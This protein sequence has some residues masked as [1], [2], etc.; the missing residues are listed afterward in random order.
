[1]RKIGISD[2]TLRKMI[3]EGKTPVSFN[4]KTEIVKSLDMLNVCVIET[5][6][7]IHGKKDVLFL[8]TVSML[9]KNSILACPVSLSEGSIVETY[10]AIKNAKKCRL[11]ISVPVSTVQMEYVCKM[12][13]ARV[14]ELITALTTKAC[15]LCSDVEVEFRDATR[16]ES[17]FLNNAIQAAVGAGA[18]NISVCDDAGDMFPSE[19]GDFI[20]GIKNSA[21]V[22]FASGKLN[23][24]AV[25]NNKLGMAL[26]CAASAL[27]AGADAIKTTVNGA[28][29]P[30]LKAL[31]A[32][33]RERGASLASEC[34]INVTKL[35][36]VIDKLHFLEDSKPDATVFDSGTGNEN[37]GDICFGADTTISDVAAALTR[38][39]YELSDDDVKNVYDELMK[40]SSKKEVGT[41]E[42]DTIIASVAM[43]VPPTFK[44]KSFVINSGD[45]ITPTANIELCKNG[46]VLRGFCIGNGPIDAAFL[47][48][49]KITGHHYELDDFQIKAVTEGFEAMGSAVVKLRHNGK[50]FSGSGTSTDI[51]GASI[52][53]YISALNKITYEEGIS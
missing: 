45:L 34:D 7:I 15:S 47:A 30:S 10:D 36:H 3:E 4:E 44:V 40:T 11:I 29:V 23:L 24:I 17:E 19:Y 9:V 26:A 16:A 43:Q 21:G 39:G 1:M 20:S 5:A 31:S 51:V 35:E 48:I 41:K 25:C 8:H 53:A 2:I 49:E 27:S 13:P 14:L 42:L 33:I 32:L 38:I 22:D 46:E 37:Y 12:K 28:V 18:K 50:I 52:Y 6:P